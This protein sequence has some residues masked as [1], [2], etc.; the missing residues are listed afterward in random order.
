MLFW[1]SILIAKYTDQGL[2]ELNWSYLHFNLKII[3]NEVIIGV[4]FKGFA[5]FDGVIVKS[6]LTVNGE[7]ALDRLC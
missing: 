5:V 3:N 6:N 7:Y 1:K 4:S 2:M